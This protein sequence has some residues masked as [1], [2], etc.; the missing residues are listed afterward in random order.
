VL[1]L[2]AFPVKKES[3]NHPSRGGEIG[4]SLARLCPEVKRGEKGEI[5]SSLSTDGIGKLAHLSY[6]EKERRKE[7]KTGIELDVSNER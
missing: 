7:E 1:F 2:R 5:L 4:Q 6:R 3:L